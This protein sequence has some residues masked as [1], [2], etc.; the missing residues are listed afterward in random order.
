MDNSQHL[1]GT[2]LFHIFLMFSLEIFPFF[3][4]DIFILFSS[5]GII[6]SFI[7]R[8]VKEKHKN[9]AATSRSHRAEQAPGWGCC[10]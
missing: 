8:D 9:K 2:A 4:E 3:L 1:S 6:P 7:K 10:H 5:L